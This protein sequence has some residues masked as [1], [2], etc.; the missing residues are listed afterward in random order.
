LCWKTK[1]DKV[2]KVVKRRYAFIV[3]YPTLPARHL[4]EMSRIKQISWLTIHFYEPNVL[5]CPEEINEILRAVLHNNE[6]K[7]FGEE[8]K[9]SMIDSLLERKTVIDRNVYYKKHYSQ[10]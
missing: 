9:M 3:N 6:V 4:I 8:V 7:Q 1:N 10:S 5:Y 2:K